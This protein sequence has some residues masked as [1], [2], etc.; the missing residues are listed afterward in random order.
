[1]HN[2][3]NYVEVSKVVSEAIYNKY[4]IVVYFVLR[5]DAE[6]LDKQIYCHWPDLDINAPILTIPNMWTS[7]QYYEA[8]NTI[9]NAFLDAYVEEL[10]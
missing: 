4:K 2:P 1:M 6:S 7:D 3:I 8:V 10:V 5:F 9:Y